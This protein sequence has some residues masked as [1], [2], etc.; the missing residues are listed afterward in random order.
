VSQ[1]GIVGSGAIAQA[2]GCALHRRGAPISAVA[3]RNRA[4]AERAAR[5]IADD[6]R[7]VTYAELA[8]LA[9][10]LIVAVSDDAIG[11]VAEELVDAGVRSG[12]VL[13]TSGAK[14][15]AALT[16]L[17]I[18]GVACGVL[19]PLQSVPSPEL[20]IAKLEGITYGVGGDRTAVEWAEHLV[21]LLN[22]RALR[23]PVDSFPIYHA[24]ATLASNA[25]P[26]LVDAAVGLMQTAGV[27]R[28]AALEALKPLY[29]ASAENVAALGPVGALTGPVS[30][31]DAATVQ[32][33]LQA[34]EHLGR[35]DIAGLYVAIA[36]CL[37]GLARR[38]GLDASQAR[39]LEQLLA[40]AAAMNEIEETA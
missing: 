34:L 8:G 11:V 23:V 7:A 13:H 29:L 10:H 3:A 28:D 40:D 37:V 20:G 14:G 39:R 32:G 21:R 12:T 5:F 2:L 38:R 35:T 26:A 31:G 19:H 6:V 36:R 4:H 15:P 18:Q 17:R 9:S 1:I 27:D 30:R 16:P 25:I 33:H 22:S 24:A